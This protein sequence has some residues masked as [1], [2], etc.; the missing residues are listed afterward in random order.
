MQIGGE[1]GTRTLDLGIMSCDFEQKS[2]LI[3][4]LSNV[5]SG[6]VPVFVRIFPGDCPYM[7]TKSDTVIG[8]SAAILYFLILF[9]H[10]CAGGE[11]ILAFRSL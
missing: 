11:N 10:G 4:S 3:Q 6:S 9:A 5:L 8:R 7:R 2:L 1:R